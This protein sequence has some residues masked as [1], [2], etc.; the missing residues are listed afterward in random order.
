MT[1]TA[2]TV[3]GSTTVTSAS[4][5]SSGEGGGPCV[6]LFEV[7]NGIDDDCDGEVDE[8]DPFLGFDCDTGEPGICQAGTFACEDGQL[9]CERKLAPAMEVC[10]GIDNDCNGK[11]D[12]VPCL[13]K[14][15]FITSQT[16]TGALGGLHGADAICQSAAETAGL[17]GTYKAWL[18]TSTEDVFAR[19]THPETPYVLVDGTKVADGFGELVN[20]G[21]QHAISLDEYG[22][23]APSTTA[24]SQLAPPS[25]T[26][27]TSTL[28]DGHIHQ[29]T[30]TCDNFTAAFGPASL[31]CASPTYLDAWSVCCSAG[32]NLCAQKAALY[33]FEQ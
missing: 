18:S 6:P 16:F 8:S 32:V 3:S 1:A 28:P 9:V 21:P 5:A 26:V 30:Q 29:E 19:F 20:G 24:C 14:T 12:E 2:V 17:S 10:D 15:V 25:A 22:N 33:C 11:V 7:C 27:W 4:D 23:P 13:P 31:G